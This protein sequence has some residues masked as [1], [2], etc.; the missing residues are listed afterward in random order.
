V[1]PQSKIVYLFVF[2]AFTNVNNGYGKS[3]PSSFSLLS[4]CL[5]M[6]KELEDEYLDNFDLSS[7]T[8][9]VF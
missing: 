2:I 6:E 8:K 3:W 7:F 4:C 9:R 5:R 1:L